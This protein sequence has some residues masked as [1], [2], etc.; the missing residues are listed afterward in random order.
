MTFR[1]LVIVVFIAATASALHPVSLLQ[2]KGKRAEKLEIGHSQ[3]Q[4][5]VPGC[6]YEARAN[7]GCCLGEKDHLV[8]CCTNKLVCGT[9]VGDTCAPEKRQATCCKDEKSTCCSKPCFVAPEVHDKHKEP[10]YRRSCK[11]RNMTDCPDKPALA[12][13]SAVVSVSANPHEQAPKRVVIPK[14]EC[15]SAQR[16]RTCCT[17]P[18]E[19]KFKCCRPAVVCQQQK[20]SSKVGDVSETECSEN[21]L[22]RKKQSREETMCACMWRERVC[23]SQRNG[24]SGWGVRRSDRRS[25]TFVRE[26]VLRTYL[27]R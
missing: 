19:H 11:D 23:V 5:Q 21:K 18:E 10:E 27:L 1:T 13:V 20:P 22:E 6:T 15:P 9:S 24:D 26:S 25:V 12:E 8:R 7:A 14:I 16:S 3:S 4:S 2:S 17:A